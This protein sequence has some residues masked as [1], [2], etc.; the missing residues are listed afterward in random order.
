MTYQRKAEP[1]IYGYLLI[2]AICAGVIA[3]AVI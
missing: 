2:L 1:G 3:P